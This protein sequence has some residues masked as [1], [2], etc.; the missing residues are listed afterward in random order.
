MWTHADKLTGMFS[1]SSLAESLNSSDVGSPC[2]SEKLHVFYLLN[3]YLPGCLGVASRVGLEQ[4]LVS[5]SCGGLCQL[6]VPAV[7]KCH[8]LRGLEQQKSMVS[9]FWRPAV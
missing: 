3:L 7:T 6:P 8:E 9:Q 4:F 5:V 1:S 2:F